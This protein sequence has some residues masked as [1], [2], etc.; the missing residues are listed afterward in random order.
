ME[1]EQYKDQI[2]VLL[3][4]VGKLPKTVVIDRGLRGLQQA[5]GGDIEQ[6]SPFYD[7]V[8]IICDEEGKLKG[9]PLNR[10]IYDEDSGEMIEIMAGDFLVVYAPETSENYESLPPELN[11][12]YAEK[13]HDPQRFCRMNGEIIAI[14]Y[15]PKRDSYE[16]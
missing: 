5:V 1:Q 12:K 15:Q 2:S 7:E 3:V 11:R 9:K 16:R 10:A 6:F 4:P 8:A 14:P 13:F